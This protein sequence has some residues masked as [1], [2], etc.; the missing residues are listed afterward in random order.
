[1]PLSKATSAAPR[2]NE[3][4]SQQSIAADPRNSV[5]IGKI[6]LYIFGEIHAPAGGRGAMLGP[7]RS[8]D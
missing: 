1:M 2:R 7:L 5:A 8:L 4:I 6:L 3:V